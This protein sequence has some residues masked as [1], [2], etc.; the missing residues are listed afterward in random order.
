MKPTRPP[1]TPTNPI[2]VRFTDSERKLLQ[3]K[4]DKYCDGN[5]SEFIR[6][7]VIAFKEKK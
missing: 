2:A 6:I 5:V 7:A 3:A 4:A 1:T